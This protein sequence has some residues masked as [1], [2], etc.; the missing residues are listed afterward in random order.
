M[1]RLMKVVA[2]IALVFG[3]TP[4]ASAQEMRRAG[5][6]GLPPYNVAKEST[7]TGQITGSE[8]SPMPQGPS[9]LVLNVTVDGQ[10]MHLFVGP[11]DWAREKGLAVAKGA[12]IEATGVSDGMHFKG[13]A[14]MVVRQVKIGAKTM[15]VR[16]A[17]GSPL[18]E[19]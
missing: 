3:L 1:S 7:I 18:W 16:A 9:W 17:D 14:A 11:E 19:K 8:L 2:A 5:G 10:A 13:D 6:N 15:A 4:L 12:T